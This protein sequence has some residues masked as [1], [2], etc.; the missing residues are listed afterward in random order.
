MITVVQIHVKMMLHVLTHKQTII[1]I[2]LKTGKERTVACLGYS[3]AAHHVKVQ[4]IDIIHVGRT[5]SLSA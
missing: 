5:L 4:L 3:A 2:V 1:V